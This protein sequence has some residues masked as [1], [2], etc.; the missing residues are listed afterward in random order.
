MY[1]E[2]HC[3]TNFSFLRGASH[4]HEL[5]FQA[6]ALGYSALAITDECSFAGIVKAY[7]AAEKCGLHLIVGSEFQLEEGFAVVALVTSRAAYSELSALITLA[8]RRAEKGSYAVRLSD[9][10][11]NLRHNLLIWRP[12]HGDSN[13]DEHAKVLREAF[14]DRLWIGVSNLLRVD[15]GERYDACYDLARRWSIPMVACGDVQ[16]HVPQRKLLHDA[17]TAIR[18]N[19]SIAGLGFRRQGNAERYLRPPRRL[20]RLYPEALLAET[21]VL[22]RRCCFSLGELKYQ[23][24]PEVVPPTMSP[25]AYLRFLVEE[26]A[27]G[28]WPAGVP[29][30]IRDQIERELQLIADLEYEYYFLTVHDIVHFAMSEQ[31][32]CQGRG[33]AANSVV[34]YCL[35]ITEVSPQKAS[36][37]FERFLSK[38]RNEPPDIDVDFEHE[39]REEVI[40]YI[41]KKYGRERAALTATVVYYRTR[42]AIRDVGKAL[43]LDP[44]FIQ[45]LSNSLAWW[46]RREDLALRFQER[47]FAATSLTSV[48]FL[49]LVQELIG[50]PRHLSQH[51]GG[52]VITAD[53]ISTLVPVENASMKDR[54]IIQWDKED[55]ES[56]KMLK[57]DVLALGML[58]AIRKTLAL[59]ARHYEPL[60]IEDIPPDDPETYEMLQRADSVGVFQ[61]ESRAQMAMLP[62]LKP[63]TYYDLVIEVALVRP[64]PIQ[65]DMVHPYLRRRQG[66]EPEDYPNEAVKAV[67]GRTLGIPIFQE[68]VIKLA[69]VAAGFSAGEADQLRRAMASWGK[70]GDLERFRDKLLLGMQERGHP[71]AFAERL[72]EQM[73][74]FGSYG[75]P[76]S[77]AASFALLVYI[78][79]YLKRHYP[80]AFYCGLLNSLPMG[81]YS[82][83][84]II[85]DA[86]RHQLTILPVDVCFSDN[87]HTLE[88]T[89]ESPLWALRLGFR[90][91]KGLRDDA[92]ETIVVA[93]ASK[94]FRS[95]PDFRRRTR[96]Q[97]D[98]VDALIA[99]DALKSLSGHRHQTH[100]EAATIEATPPLD[101]E[102]LDPGDGIA[103]PAP[104]EIQ[105][106]T[107]DY[108]SV[109]LT[110]GRHPMEL[111]RE[112]Y[113][114]FHQCRRQT[115]LPG[116]NQGRF[117]RVAG[118]VT[119][120]QRPGTTTGVV[121]ITLEDETGNMNVVVWKDVQERCRD[122]LLKAKL[123][124][125]KG[126]VETD[127]NVT[128]VIAGEL[129]D[130]SHYL[131]DMRLESRDFH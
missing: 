22:A 126:L 127:H 99:A 97:Q 83:S 82:P 111:L 74:G 32:L 80:V 54:T 102:A 108:N 57:V 9:L 65:G 119:G 24:P 66:L 49:D 33:S 106:L 107:A 84:Q 18:H 36:L 77:H 39:R 21:Q 88:R 34:C 45:E 112:R 90:L 38:E 93:R 95:L 72:F 128:H 123:L 6:A 91:V 120:R 42:S 103:L 27:A 13:N 70:N 25:A 23:Y 50:F 109:G 67:L 12:G 114:L 15:E 118:I 1:A 75:F 85:Q 58:T 16:M 55:I 64:G 96:L 48:R 86:R 100:W 87:D 110:L 44:L 46:D 131:D 63:K 40:Q 69:M 105:E 78:S 5:V 60:R 104:T 2:L 116:L 19:T 17:A 76:E 31:I 125:V 92:A 89:G 35:R 113:P 59:L 71:R 81:F 11:Y 4:P 73:K 20:R 52:F 68:Q 56:M 53:P 124:M 122:A 41:Y 129:I 29:A 28:R 30:E 8:R 115:E 94:P 47:G 51:V 3:L 62:R 101:L 37:L 10:E 98:Q 61:V 130:C 14:P 43:G 121:F 26:G 117:V 7:V 79:S